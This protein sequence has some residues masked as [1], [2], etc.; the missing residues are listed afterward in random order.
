MCCFL[1]DRWP[2]TPCCGETKTWVIVAAKNRACCPGS[3]I[4][5]S[6]MKML[7]PRDLCGGPEIFAG[8]DPGHLQR[9]M[10]VLL[11]PAET[12]TWEGYVGC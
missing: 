5:K 3:R 2:I 11:P 10:E 4:D 12:E 1:I 6:A 8:E 9:T 7:C